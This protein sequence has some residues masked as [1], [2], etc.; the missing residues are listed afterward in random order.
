MEDQTLFEVYFHKSVSEWQYSNIVFHQPYEPYGE[1]VTFEC[2]N[3]KNSVPKQKSRSFGVV[4]KQD[5]VLRRDFFQI[6]RF[7]SVVTKTL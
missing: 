6:W 7:T 5:F 4:I 3:Q 1:R 2:I